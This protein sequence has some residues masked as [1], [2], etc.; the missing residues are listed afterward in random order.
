MARILSSNHFLL[1]LV[2]TGILF[3]LVNAYLAAHGNVAV[4]GLL[5]LAILIGFAV[6]VLLLNAMTWIVQ[7]AVDTQ[8]ERRERK[9]MQ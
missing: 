8:Y 9:E 3:V 1:A 6:L 2:S 4:A 7:K 5:L